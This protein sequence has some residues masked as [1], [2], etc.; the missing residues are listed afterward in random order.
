VTMTTVPDGTSNT[1]LVAEKQLNPQAYSGDWHDDQGWIDSWD[2]DTVRYT[3]FTP[4][5]DKNYLTD[6]WQGYRFGSAHTNGMLALFGDGSARFLPFSID[7]TM[8]NRLGDRQ[9]GQVVNLP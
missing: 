1:L 7:P 5:S 2:P 6:S 8:F 3:G 4:S 9:D